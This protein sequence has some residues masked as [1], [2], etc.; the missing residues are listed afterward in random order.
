M[1]LSQLKGRESMLR[2]L[3]ISIVC[4]GFLVSPVFATVYY[5]KPDGSGDYPTIQSAI[6]ATVDGDT[7]LL[8]DGIFTGSFNWNINMATH[9]ILL[10]SENGRDHSIID[11]GSGSGGYQ[12]GI[13]INSGEGSG[14]IIDGITVRN[15]RTLGGGGTGIYIG[16]GAS[17]IIRN[18]AI[19]GNLNTTSTTGYGVGIAIN[20][21]N[22]IIYNNLIYDN[23]FSG[24]AGYGAGIYVND[25][26]PVISGNDISYNSGG[27]G[28]AGIFIVSDSTVTITNNIFEGNSC[29]TGSGGAIRIDAITNPPEHHNIINNL[30]VGN[31]AVE[32]GGIYISEG[33]YA[34]ECCT[35]AFNDGGGLYATS[36]WVFHCIF[37]GNTGYQVATSPSVTYCWVEGGFAGIGNING[38]T[39]DFENGPL[40]GYYLPLGNECFDAGYDWASTVCFNDG[41]ATQCLDTFTVF[42]KQ[43]YDDDQVDLGFHYRRVPWTYYVPDDFTMIQNGLDTLMTGD[44]LVV[45]P[46]TYYEA[47]VDF[48]ARGIELV[49]E[50]GPD[51]TTIHADGYGSVL[52]IR[53]GEGPGTIIDGF[54][55]REGW[56]SG[57]GG[58]IYCTG[59]DPTIRNCII[60]WNDSDMGG[61]GMYCAN[62][63]ATISNCI[64]WLNTVSGGDDEGGGLYIAG[65]G[66][67]ITI[68][69]CTFYGNTAGQ[70]AGIHAL[71][72]NIAIKY[73]IIAGNITGEG[74]YV[75][76][77]A[78]VTF[79][80]CDIINNDG[81]D[82]MP[83]F[84]SQYGINHNVRVDPVFCNAKIGNFTLSNISPCLGMPQ[85]YGHMG[86]RAKGCQCTSYLLNADG[87][88]DFMTIQNAVDSIYGGDII[89]LADG[90]YTG[91]GNRDVEFKTKSVIIKSQSGIPDSCVIDCQGSAGNAHRGFLIKEREGERATLQDLTIKNGYHESASGMGVQI[92][93]SSPTVQNCIF[94]DCEGF[95]GGALS[96]YLSHSVIRN[97][98]FY[99][100]IANDAG[101]GVFVHTCDPTIEH[102]LFQGNWAKWGGGG[103][104]NHYAS[105]AVD[106]CTFILN[107][108][109]H[110]GGAV[111]NNH[112]DSTPMLSNCT[113]AYNFAPSGGAMYSR[114]NANPAVHNSII[115][116]STQGVA[117]MCATGAATDLYCCDVYGNVGGDYVDCL[118]G[119]LV[120]N[121]NFTADP[122]FCDSSTVNYHLQSGSPCAPHN[123]LVCGLVGAHSVGC[124]ATGVEEET[125]VVPLAYRLHAIYPNPFNPHCTVRFELPKAGRV[126]VRLYN[127]SGA[128]VRTLIDEWRVSGIH[129]E[130]WDGRGD[131]GEALASGIYFCRMAAGDFVASRK[132]VLLR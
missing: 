60:T 18:C 61:G 120:L 96:M 122:L 75:S 34:I 37:R 21:S 53:S 117:A 116:F 23:D 119:Q 2:R 26:S 42:A 81:G 107:S 99:D 102:C 39:L 56:R 124:S 132:I 36:G 25:C 111:H 31:S 16:N 59:S 71:D 104:Y 70:G 44:V 14:C 76:S 28:G 65:S 51:V 12:R 55:L 94:R 52:R 112:P 110:W 95:D 86:A 48:H 69:Q 87:S 15:A 100:N 115:A 128:C 57:F 30:F 80:Y 113:F 3:T 1:V 6:D 123:N 7:V 32:G 50:E 33:S 20:N 66:S 118:S 9:E 78:D 130:N 58:G 105:P 45:R 98:Q 63:E 106:Y 27:N 125:E 72:G 85:P 90:V 38:V 83:P 35:F 127:V 24:D 68:E 91:T 10:T 74:I 11:C 46:G 29:Y 40:G 126:V 8:A 17:P 103:L 73:S 13:I 93:R 62:S 79:E 4:L 89:E 22:P 64:F 82:W 88:G 92:H 108:S 54:T 101:G 19:Y 41:F 84:T 97:C 49:S 47:D 114:N 43:L 121:D 129:E 77:L 5:V 67:D 131:T 109:D